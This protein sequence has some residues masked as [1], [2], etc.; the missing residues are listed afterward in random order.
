MTGPECIALSDL[1]DHVGKLFGPT[2][3][4][5]IG[6]AMTNDFARLTGD[7]QWLHIDVE[8]ATQSI[9]GTLVHGYFTLSLIPA[10]M[11]RL[12]AISGVG[13]ALNYGVN[14]VRFPAALPVGSRVR[15]SFKLIDVL[16]RR[17]GMLMI[18]E[19]SICAT[20]A[21]RPACV[22]ETLILLI[23]GAGIFGPLDPL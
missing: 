22:A 2:E 23:P 4:I 12:I 13:Q 9:G 20:G 11:A 17:E 7:R 1:D 3:P 5:I 14:K 6:Q 15:G 19:H 18:C 16:A 8:R 10:F 21:E